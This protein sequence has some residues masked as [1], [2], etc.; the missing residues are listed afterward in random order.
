MP[1]K[2]FECYGGPLD[3]QHLPSPIELSAFGEPDVGSIMIHVDDAGQPHI[4][5]LA[6]HSDDHVKS[7]RAVLKYRGPSISAALQRIYEHDPEMGAAIGR[8]LSKI[9]T[10]MSCEEKHEEDE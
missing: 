10:D 2:I 5:A 3:G 8:D 1:K 9:L 4:Y 7:S 6:Q